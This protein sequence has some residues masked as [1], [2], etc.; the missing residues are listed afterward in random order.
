M[1][2]NYIKYIKNTNDNLCQ[3]SRYNNN[4]TATA[5]NNNNT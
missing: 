1:H 4:D 5:T 3:F 2:L